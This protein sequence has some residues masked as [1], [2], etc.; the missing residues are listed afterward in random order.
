MPNEFSALADTIA[1]LRSD[2]FLPALARYL[3]HCAAFD[4]I[5]VIVFD[6]AKTPSVL[7][8]QVSG[9]DVFRFIDALYLPGA[10]VLDPIYHV[11]TDRGGPGLYRLDDVASDNFRRSHYYEWYYG[12]IG[13]IDEITV[14][15][16]VGDSVTITISMG[17][18]ESSGQMF[19]TRTK[20][21]L[22]R[23]APVIMALLLAHWRAAP[24][25]GAAIT[26]GQP[27]ADRL[28]EALGR[29]HNVHLSARQ[30]DVA[31]LILR[32]HSTLSIGMRLEISLLTGVE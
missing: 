16:P 10:Y 20:E 23:R 29:R 11:H 26:S 7:L 8:R 17:R 28:R 18:D 14:L 25:G 19:T 22:E 1:A 13:I 6:G 3:G 31:L 15:L 30:A 21:A 5:V 4:N 32:G 24:H 9:P 27:I 2:R 12:R